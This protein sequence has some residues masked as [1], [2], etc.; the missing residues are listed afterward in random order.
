MSAEVEYLLGK[1]SA[2]EI[3]EHLI[4]CDTDFV[5]P[6]SGRVKLNDY[7][8]KIVNKATRF[9]AWSGGTLVG[10]AAAYCN[11]QVKRVAYVTSISVL[12]AWTG[13]GIAASLM[14]RCIEHAKALGMRQ[15]SLEVAEENS[16]AIRLYEKSGFV[17]GRANP[18]FVSMHL[19]LKSGEE[20]E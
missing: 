2:T 19:F 9:E 12:K 10:L 5:P 18:P 16:P 8:E 20:H 6:L 14:S 3:A 15:I 4:H 1:A 13:K 11:D 17:V 7:A